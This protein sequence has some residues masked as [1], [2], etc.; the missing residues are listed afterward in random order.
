MLIELMISYRRVIEKI[1]EHRIMERAYGRRGLSARGHCID[2][3]ANRVRNR[4]KAYGFSGRAMFF[5]PN[6]GFS[7]ADPNRGL[8]RGP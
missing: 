8:F 2:E 6:V 7:V 3:K 1:L 5:D 4:K